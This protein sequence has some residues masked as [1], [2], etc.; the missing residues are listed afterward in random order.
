MW[1]IL[2]ICVSKSDILGPNAY[3]SDI[4]NLVFFE[5]AM[6]EVNA[7]SIMNGVHDKYKGNTFLSI[8]FGFI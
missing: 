7:W 1:L 8:H 5:R 4:E 6:F 3:I 2:Y